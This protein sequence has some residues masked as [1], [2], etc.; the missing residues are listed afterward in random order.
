MSVKR[1]VTVS[2]WLAV[3]TVMP[4]T[5][6]A[7]FDQ[8]YGPAACAPGQT[9]TACQWLRQKLGGVRHAPAIGTTPAPEPST[10]LLLGLGLAGL[11]A[12]DRRKAHTLSTSSLAIRT[13]AE[14]ADR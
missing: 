11:I 6:L 5:S 10:L 13:R 2:V 9:V 8:C 1:N 12:V 3:F 4:R 14:R 7:G